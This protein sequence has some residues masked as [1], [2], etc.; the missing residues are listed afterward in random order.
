MVA[1]LLHTMK[2]DSASTSMA[3]MKA[4][5]AGPTKPMDE[6]RLCAPAPVTAGQ[7]GWD[8]LKWVAIASVA[9]GLPVILLR[10]VAGL[11]RGLLD[12]NILMTVAVAGKRKH[13][14]SHVL[15]Y[16]VAI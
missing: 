1:F 6:G 16:G 15:V 14:Q 9:I 12:I 10:A 11:R 5:H 4:W 13:A 2:W 8:Y 3:S 7:H